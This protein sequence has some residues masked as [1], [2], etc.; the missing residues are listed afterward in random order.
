MEG[1]PNFIDPADDSAPPP[2]TDGSVMAPISL[3]DLPALNK[4]LAELEKRD[5]KSLD[6]QRDLFK[7]VG[8]CYHEMATLLKESG[9]EEGWTLAMEDNGT[10]IYGNKRKIELWQ[11][12]HK[13]SAEGLTFHTFKC[14]A[15]LNAPGHRIVALNSDFKDQRRKKWED[16]D[17]ASIRFLH[18]AWKPGFRQRKVLKMREKL[19]IIESY[20]EPPTVASLMGAA[21][22]R[23]LGAQFCRR[24]K[25]QWILLCRTLTEE[26]KKTEQGDER[27]PKME[28]YQ[29]AIDVK[30]FT[31]LFVK[32]MPG[33]PEKCHVTAILYMSPG[34]WLPDA[35]VTL[36]KGKLIER[37]KLYERECQDDTWVGKGFSM[38]PMKV[39]VKLFK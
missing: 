4:R 32:D 27:Y 20:V 14:T 31:G 13:E 22:R 26:L 19:D 35:A 7:M 5:R 25:G 6:V 34:G 3:E 11:K 36:Y 8:G 38:E 12:Q 17:L 9:P 16:S 1:G 10:D 29:N 18:H 37:M 23:F 33:T 2:R 24:D 28:G 30:G 21:P 39:R 15:V